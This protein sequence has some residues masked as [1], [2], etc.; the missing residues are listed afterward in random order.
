MKSDKNGFVRTLEAIL[1]LL[2]TLLFVIFVVPS[3]SAPSYEEKGVEV[4]KP[5]EQDSDFRNYVI[6]LD[7]NCV[8]RSD[9][10]PLNDKINKYL[11]PVYDYVVCVSYKGDLASLNLPE[12]HVFVDSLLV[13]AN[14]SVY[15]PKIIRLYYWT[16]E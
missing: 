1:A 5:L 3:K 10:I 16:A 13:S 7:N 8:R 15:D 12:K 6:G 11:P 14:L 9:G 4:L 2:I